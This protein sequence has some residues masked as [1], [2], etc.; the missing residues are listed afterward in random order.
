M[1]TI[2]NLGAASR[3]EGFWAVDNPLSKPTTIA[4]PC[5]FPLR[6]CPIVDDRHENPAKAGFYRRT[7]SGLVF[8]H[9]DGTIDGVKPYP[10]T[11]VTDLASH[12]PSDETLG[13]FQAEITAIYAAIDGFSPDV[14]IYSFW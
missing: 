8:A 14:C 12:V 2:S 6:W 7:G 4:E 1:G 9:A 3:R 11:A 5:R 13:G 10:G